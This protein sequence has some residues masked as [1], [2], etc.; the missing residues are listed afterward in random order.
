VAARATLIALLLCLLPAPLLAAAGSAA[1]G[2]EIDAFIEGIGSSGCRF[3]RNGQWHDA[4]Q[5]KAHLQRKHAW[6]QRCGLAGDAE[7]F[8]ARAATAS[9]VS[10][11]AYRIACPGQPE[12]DSAAWFTA[13]LQQLRGG[14]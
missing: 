6:L 8:I 12:T 3:Q 5:A 1:A 13:R 9:N 11:R 14:R 10:G 7:L 4:A 2:A